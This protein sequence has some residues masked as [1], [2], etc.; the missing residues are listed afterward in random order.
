M[1]IEK[2]LYDKASDITNIDYLEII[3]NP[4]AKYAFISE[5]AAYSIITDLIHEIDVLKEKIED[6]EQ[7]IEDNYKPITKEEQYDVNFRDF[8]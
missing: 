5:Y 6:L 4:G 8:I 7:D 3:Y 2:E 1:L